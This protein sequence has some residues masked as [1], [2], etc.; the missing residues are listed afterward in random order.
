MGM[1]TCQVK[2]SKKEKKRLK[3]RAVVLFLLL[4]KREKIGKRK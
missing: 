2:Q 3:D 1:E 4:V